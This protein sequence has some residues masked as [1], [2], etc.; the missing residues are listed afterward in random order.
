MIFSLVKGSNLCYN[1]PKEW[2]IIIFHPPFP[3]AL[4]QTE[5]GGGD[6]CADPGGV[7]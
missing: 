3:M 7:P 1:R 2:A 4:Q 6:Y 5:K